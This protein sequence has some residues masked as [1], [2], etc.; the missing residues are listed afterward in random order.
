MKRFT[1]ITLITLI[2]AFTLTGC[3]MESLNSIDRKILGFSFGDL[4]D[5]TKEKIAEQTEESADV[6]KDEAH[7]YNNTLDTSVFEDYN[8][9][10]LKG[11]QVM[12]TIPNL[13]TQNCA[14]LISTNNMR[15][16]D[17]NMYI[18]V[19]SLLTVYDDKKVKPRY[20]AREAIYPDSWSDYISVM[21][22]DG[23]TTNDSETAF[24]LSYNNAIYYGTHLYGTLYTVDNYVA[25]TTDWEVLEDENSIAYVR[26]GAMFNA[27][28]LYKY[29]SFTDTPIGIIFE[30]E[31]Y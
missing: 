9:T 17:S 24:I 16:K 30:E 11:T 5:N 31:E 22:I 1:L 25:F 26:P 27:R 3:S 20:T 14:I 15:S 7:Y 6:V 12:A 8:R 18:N 4:I 21:P 19:G 29:N 28:V 13:G 2:T 10:V 23:I